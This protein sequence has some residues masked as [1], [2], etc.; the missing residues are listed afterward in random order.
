MKRFIVI[1]AVAGLAGCATPPAPVALSTAGPSSEPV[2]ADSYFRD[3]LSC[4]DNL[5][6]R[7]GGHRYATRLTAFPV[8]DPTGSVSAGTQ[9]MVFEAAMA[10][11]RSSRYFVVVDP[12]SDQALAGAAFMVRG[13]VTEFD[14]GV[15]GQSQSAG[16]GL[17]GAEIG[18]QTNF[19]VSGVALQLRLVESAS[20]A[21]VPGAHATH[22]VALTQLDRG[23]D[24]RAEVGTVAGFLDFQVSRQQALHQSVKALIDL[25]MIQI[26][27]EYAGV[28]YEQCLS[29]ASVTAEAAERGADAWMELTDP[30]RF[31]A[32]A[33]ALRERGYYTGPVLLQQE[34]GPLRAAVAA[35]QRDNQLPA[36]GRA[37]LAVFNALRLSDPAAP[38]G[39]FPPSDIIVPMVS[40][41]SSTLTLP[42]PDTAL[43][44]SNRRTYLAPAGE[45]VVFSATLSLAGY[46]VCFNESHAGEIVRVYP[47]DRRT[48]RR[49]EA[50]ERVVMPNA[51]D[52]YEIRPAWSRQFTLMDRSTDEINARTGAFYCLASAT[53][54]ANSWP[55]QWGSVNDAP[56]AIPLRA[57]ADG[58][59][60]GLL[61]QQFRAEF[62]GQKYITMEPAWTPSI[63]PVLTPG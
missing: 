53:P 38:A 2:A 15:F 33:A 1:L 14:Q 59:H 32:V 22:R 43:H 28:P 17:D 55:G 54:F 5:L 6:S 12:I 47:N 8:T 29:Q 62:A 25:G 42:S 57:Q 37:G 20:G 58:S 50:N 7:R 11:S 41:A 40:A 39:A 56:S 19:T 21:I 26:V 24:L 35:F 9:A 45:R 18:A 51:L 63:E 4:M 48:E 30:E 44:L 3:A 46:L 13:E 31:S 61:Q 23:A 10:M 49:L 52:Q 16:L 36:T 60:H 34:T 27:G